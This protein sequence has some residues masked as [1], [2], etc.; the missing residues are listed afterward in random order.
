VEL[1]DTFY[2]F[3][4][5]RFGPFSF[6]LYH[7]L[8]NLIREGVVEVSADSECVLTLNKGTDAACLDVSTER[9]IREFLRRYGQ[10][11]TSML[12]DIVYSGYKWFTLKSDFVE[13]RA[14]KESV[15]EPAIYTAGY[16]GLH[17]DAFFN[18]L[19]R[20]GIKR[21]IDVRANP[22]S[23][24]YGFHKK[25]FS[26][27]S[28]KLGIEYLHYPAVGVPSTWRTELT[29]IA[30][31]DRLFERY[32]REIISAQVELIKEIALKME[33]AV[34]VLVCQEAEPIF[35]HRSPLARAIAL[36]SPL[37]PC[38]IRR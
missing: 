13:K 5:Y 28:N 12:M 17:V 8:D 24:R 4:P 27:I 15:P 23:R 37:K 22:I 6:T 25:T 9:R 33:E 14:L 10:M 21:L 32:Q 34:S 36:V 19:L 16:E 2:E 26:G 35:C 29:G 11:D 30:S 38:D 20:W 31:Y 1:G 18:L 3:L 7:E